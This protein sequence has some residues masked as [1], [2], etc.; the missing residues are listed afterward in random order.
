MNPNSSRTLTWGVTALMVV[1]FALSLGW[2]VNQN[3]QAGM[4]D[5]DLV[6]SALLLA[7]PIVLLFFSIG[8]LIL[9]WAQRRSQEQISGRL[10]WAI[11]YTPRIAG[12]LILLFVAMFSLDVFGAGLSFW[13]TVGAFFMHNLITIVMA[14]ILALAWQRPVYGFVAFLLL[15][16]FFLRSLLGDPL[17]GLGHIL[18]FSGPMA[19]I[20]MLF[21]VNWKWQKGIKAPHNQPAQP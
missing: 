14:I 18:I 15:A 17:Q 11:Y 3:Y 16:I 21:W 8:L 19:A 12:V 1:L 9:A 20:A 7:I 10:G 6:S 2:F 4:R 13:E 5:W